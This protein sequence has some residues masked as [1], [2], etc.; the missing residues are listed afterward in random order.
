MIYALAKI[1]E[2]EQ[3]YFIYYHFFR[4]TTTTFDPGCILCRYQK[5][6]DFHLPKY[7]RHDQ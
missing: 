7:S 6:K 4:K 5:T 3:I 1:I 2:L